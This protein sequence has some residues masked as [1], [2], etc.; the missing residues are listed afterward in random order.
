M[1]IS[2]KVVGGLLF[3]KIYIIARKYFSPIFFGGRGR[4]GHVPPPP[5]V[6]YAYVERLRRED[7]GAKVAEGLGVCALLP[8]KI[9]GLK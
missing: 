8:R 1:K 7:R 2:L 6:S 9:L 4:G 5:P 3:T